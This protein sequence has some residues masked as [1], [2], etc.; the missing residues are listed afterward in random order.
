[1][2]VNKE[3]TVLGGVLGLAAAGLMVDR[4]FL[5]GGFS[6]PQS[7]GAAPDT[8][9][10]NASSAPKETPA[11]VASA[12]QPDSL[13]NRFERFAS[14]SVLDITE[15]GDAMSGEGRKVSGTPTTTRAQ[16]DYMDRFKATYEFCLAIGTPGGPYTAYLKVRD[17]PSQTIRVREGEVVDGFTLERVEVDVT[18][19][20]IAH[21]RKEARTVA[22][23]RSD[24]Q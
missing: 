6:G 22:L 4:V 7:A 20:A 3:R 13:T 14:T 8:S 16:P 10:M 19:N 21:F 9:V 23:S 1:M 17:N 11:P 18:G 24:G 12:Q 15:M 2:K 5:D